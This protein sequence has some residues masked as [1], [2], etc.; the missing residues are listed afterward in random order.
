METR[1]TQSGRD[2]VARG[3]AADD[4][5]SFG[6]SSSRN[7]RSDQKRKAPRTATA[8]PYAMTR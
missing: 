4:Q 6:R 5:R 2:G 8:K 1:V 7:R 3:T